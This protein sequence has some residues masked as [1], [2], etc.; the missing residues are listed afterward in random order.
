[1]KNYLRILIPSVFLSSQS[2]LVTKSRS[3]KWWR[4]VGIGRTFSDVIS[5]YK[6][7]SECGNSRQERLF[8][9][10][11][12]SNNLLQNLDV[13][14]S[15]KF[16]TFDAHFCHTHHNSNRSRLFFGNNLQP[17]LDPKNLLRAKFQASSQ[18][19][20]ITRLSLWNQSLSKANQTTQRWL[21]LT[22][23][24]LLRNFLT[25]GYRCNRKTCLVC[26]EI[27]QKKRLPKLWNQL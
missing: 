17:S 11:R 24:E 22:L 10:C 19:L 2:N 16:E 26:D 7:F 13:C 27:V 14:D 23:K 25:R 12:L 15:P 4:N 20:F 6:L 18:I 9:V 1:M 8:A 5:R 3:T 21:V